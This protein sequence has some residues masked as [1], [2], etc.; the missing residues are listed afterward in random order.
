MKTADGSP[1]PAGDGQQLEGGLADRAVDVVDENQDF[2]S[3]RSPAAPQMNFLAARNSTSAAAPEPPSSLTISPAVRGG[4]ALGPST[5]VQAAARPTCAGVDAQVGQ[6]PGLHRLLLRG[7]DPLE[8]RVAGL[9]GLVGHRQHQRQR[10]LDDLGGGVAVALDAD[11]VALGLDR[12]RRRSPA[13]TPSARRASPAP[14]HRAVGRGHAAHH[15]VARRRS[16][17]PPRPAPARW[18]ARRSRRWRRRRR[19]RPCRHPSA[20]PCAP[21]RWPPRGRR[22]RGHGDSSP[23]ALLLD[24]QRLLDGV[25]VQLGEQP[26]D[27]RRGPRSCPPRSCRSAVASGTYFTHTTM[28]MAYGLV[29]PSCA[30][31]I[32]EATRGYP[33]YVRIR[34]THACAGSHAAPVSLAGWY[35]RRADA[36]QGLG[37]SRSQ[38]P[39]DDEVDHA[40][41]PQ[42]TRAALVSA[43]LPSKCRCRSCG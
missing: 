14:P 39:A 29:G 20:A 38:D 32:A 37:R 28:F 4:R 16:S 19:G 21:R 23:S 42:L 25:L 18:P 40:A 26:V 11:L 27:A 43:F 31:V 9:A 3:C 8:G 12:P 33:R 15:Q 7:H 6:R 17:R 34:L 2:S 5:S 1:E 24:L 22:Q 35:R 13:G 36:G 41:M 10:A 30:S